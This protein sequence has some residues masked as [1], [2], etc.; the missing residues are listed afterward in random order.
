MSCLNAGTSLVPL[1]G[2]G[3]NE[4]DLLAGGQLAPHRRTSNSLATK[5]ESLSCFTGLIPSVAASQPRGRGATPCVSVAAEGP[6]A[7][8]PGGNEVCIP[9]GASDSLLL[10]RGPEAEDGVRSVR[11][12]HDKTGVGGAHT[13]TP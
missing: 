1:S 11:P 5:K 6:P 2:C 8:R 3:H 7:A 12:L 9:G 4:G 10:P 13:S